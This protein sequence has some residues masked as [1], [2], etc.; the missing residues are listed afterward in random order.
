MGELGY[1]VIWIAFILLYRLGIGRWTQWD[2]IERRMAYRKS[3]DET[4]RRRSVWLSMIGFLLAGVALSLW[5]LKTGWGL[6]G[7][8][9]EHLVGAAGAALIGAAVAVGSVDWRGGENAIS[10]PGA[11][12]SARGRV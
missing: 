1:A 8:P 4:V 10:S 11:V 5:F 12:E 3:P 2:R 6:F 7:F 9:I